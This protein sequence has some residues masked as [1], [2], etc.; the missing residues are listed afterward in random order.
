MTTDFEP[1]GSSGCFV[2]GPS[3]QGQELVNVFKGNEEVCAETTC[4]ILCDY[5]Q[6]RSGAWREAAR[7]RGN[8][9][10]DSGCVFIFYGVLVSMME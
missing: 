7:F 9:E 6:R 8:V 5:R 1:E 10:S 2:S 4:V 3:H